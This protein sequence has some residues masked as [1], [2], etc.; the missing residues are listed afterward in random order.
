MSLTY[1]LRSA[2]KSVAGLALVVL[3]SWLV[4]ACG[5]GD[6]VVSRTRYTI[7][8]SVAGLVGSGLVLQDNGADSLTVSSTGTFTFA[9]PLSNSSSYAVTVST[10]PTNPAQTCVVASGSGSVIGTNV[11]SVAVTCTT[12][13]YTV[14]GE[15]TGLAGSGLILQDNG[16]DDLPI[17][18]SGNF[19]FAH[20]VGSGVDYAV[21]VKTQPGNPTQ[22]CSVSNA[23]GKMGSANV[24]NVVVNCTTSSFS[25]SGT[26]SG[27]AGTG[28]ILQDNAGDDL[29]ITA[30]GSF[31]FA[32]AVASGATYAVTVKAQPTNPTQTCAV[33]NGTGT[34]G[35][36]NVTNVAVVC[37]I[38]TYTVGGSVTG[39]TGS[40]LV[41][42][43]NGGNAVAVASSGNYIFATLPSGS[44]Y[45]VTVRTQ[46]SSPTQA[47]VVTAGSG[48]IT[49]ANVT[50]VVV[51]CTTTGFPVGGTASGVAGTG[52][53]VL[54][55]GANPVPVTGNGAFTVATI[56][57]GTQYAITVGTQP[58]TPT[59]TCVVGNGTGTV[60]NAAVTNVTLTCTTNS[61]AVGGTVSGLS[62]S[63]LQIQNAGVAYAI[64]AN[65]ANQTYVS[66]P[67]GTHYTFSIKTQP[68]SPSQTC[69][70]ANPTGTV[71]NAAVTNVNV[72]CATNLYTIGG[73]VS[74]LNGSGLMLQDNGG[75]TLPVTAN[76]TF[77]FATKL[78]NAAA[79]AVTVSTQPTS[80]T[81][82]CIVSSGSGTVPAANVTSV[83]VTCR[84]QGQYVF[85][86]DSAAGVV[87]SF[88]IAP[89]TGALT[90]INSATASSTTAAPNGITVNVPTGGA[91]T[92]LY[93]ADSGAADISIFTVTAGT[94]AYQ[95]DVSTATALTGSTPTSITID[96]SGTFAL[97]ADSDTGAGG[98]GGSIFVFA[99]SQSGGVATLTP[100]VGSPN[101]ASASVPGNATDD[102]V[103]DPSD[104]YVFASNQFVPSLA[105]FTFNNP[106]TS[107]NLTPSTPT[108]EVPTGNNPVWVTVDPLDRFVY[109]SNA[110]D[111]TVSGWT[112]GGG[113][114]LS[115]IGGSPFGTGF[116]TGA[117]PGGMAIDPAGQFLYVADTAN[118]QVVAFV[119]NQ[120]TGALSPMTGSPFA[121]GNGTNGTGPFAV[122]IDPSG[123]FLYTGNTYDG[124]ISMFTIDPSSGALS[125]IGGSPLSYNDVGTTPALGSNALAV[126]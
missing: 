15:V 80:P 2:T 92:F 112:L 55:N 53:T 29:P 70:I 3:T 31:T 1:L 60:T 94:V 61:Y 18:A 27:L 88:T 97:M 99:T 69:V 117:N 84:N 25:V 36:A 10:Q 66:L 116:S 111:G 62:G 75:D 5:G 74:G 123:H 58:S 91:N 16:G 109:V 76:G 119:I 101:F 81:Q 124:T 43:T 82:Y 126:Q 73:T 106:A 32:T 54:N 120:S 102:V 41:M 38:N 64:A 22:S 89:I 23:S 51:T 107:G 7:G 59:Q 37:T 71:T 100:A 20:T 87:S 103:V 63:G 90:L 17:T 12:N 40:G 105:G 72:S 48:T 96:P 57:S 50:N 125:T 78:T 33:T 42:Q 13:G 19:T 93:T 8:G 14:G 79:Y 35:S 110:T 21:T 6:S 83:T 24:T 28:L 121:T 34:I 86:A 65:G 67:S 49:S 39:L 52:L 104:T 46:P 9:T 85:S 26:V 95:G 30:S 45:A 47:C 118:A 115:T 11:Q 108:W 4:V 56:A 98:T 44:A 77:T 68:S 114:V 113:G 122:N